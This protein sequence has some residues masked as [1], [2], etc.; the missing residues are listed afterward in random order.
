MFL[1]WDDNMI[2]KAELKDIDKI[3]EI[4]KDAKD[5]LKSNGSKQWNTKDGYPNKDTIKT[6]ISN[7]WLY[8]YEEEQIKGII[9]ILG[10]D[11]NYD[12]I[13]GAWLDNKEYLSLHRLAVKKEFYGQNIGKKLLQFAES[14]ARENSIFSIR[15]DTHDFNVPMQKV[16]QKSGYTFC[17]I[18]KLK[19][20]AEDNLRKAYQKEAVKKPNF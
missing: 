6:D 4:I 9:A 10:H 3:M 5:L 17:G 12:E 1:K 11:E 15:V 13:N 14:F 8:L 16:L 2:R 19:R 7:N 20:T 18:I